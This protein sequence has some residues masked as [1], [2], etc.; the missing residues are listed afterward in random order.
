MRQRSNS[1]NSTDPLKFTQGVHRASR[2]SRIPRFG[3]FG[4]K[5]W[6]PAIFSACLVCLW[7]FWNS[8]RAIAE[9][10]IFQGVS[11]TCQT[12]QPTEKSSGWVH[13]VR[14]DLTTPGIELYTTPVD[15]TLA[16]E[17]W[18]YCLMLT[19]NCARENDLSVAI[20][21][22]QF[23]SNSYTVEWKGKNRL[24]CLPGD[25]ARTSEMV[26]SNY[27]ANPPQ[28][29]IYLLWFDR[30]LTPIL[31]RAR[32][33]SEE[34]LREAR[35]GVGSL[36]ILAQDGKLLREGKA[37]AI[38]RTAIGIDSEK[39]LLWLAVFEK[40]SPNAAG[41]LLISLGARDVVLMDG[42]TSSA[43]ALGRDALGVPTGVVAGGW[44]PVATHFG[45]R[46]PKLREG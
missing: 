32:P 5:L 25:L 43:M 31:E 22:T 9:K 23:S 19:G 17:Q 28:D 35:W 12:L 29:N 21:A 37:D 14:V 3:R 15:E 20:N 33:P 24:F 30:D 42:G 4:W 11:Y 44:R 26:V 27:Q 40:A 8:P 2:G 10:E 1:S 34:V 45:I 38:G 39:K 13:I 7:Y 18:Q 41:K 6:L 46:A 16:S 36:S